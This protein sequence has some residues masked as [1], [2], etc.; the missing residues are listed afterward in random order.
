MNTTVLL[1]T[2][3]Y[4][5]H[6]GPVVFTFEAAATPMTKNGDTSGSLSTLPYLTVLLKAA[7]YVCTY[8]IN[9]GPQ[10]VNRK[11]TTD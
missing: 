1:L 3:R 2:N 11:R 7:A 5:A 4:N 9:A 8:K 6:D 10:R